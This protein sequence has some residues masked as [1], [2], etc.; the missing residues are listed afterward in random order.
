MIKSFIDFN[1]L[2]KNQLI[3]IIDFAKKIKKNPKKYDSLLKNKSLG[4]LFEKQSTRTRLSFS[5]GMMKLGGNVIELNEN[6]IGFGKRESMKDILKTMSQYLDVLMIRND[7]HDQLKNLDSLNIMPIING[8]SNFSHPCQIL[9]DVLTIEESLGSIKNKEITW[10]GDFNNVLISLIQA[11][12]IFKFKLNILVPRSLIKKYDKKIK[13]NDLKFSYFHDNFKEGLRNAD[14][15]MTDVW[16]SM[17]EKDI[18][19]KKRILKKYQVNDNIMK[20]ANKNAIFMHCLPAH[21]NEEVTSSVIDGN[22]S[23][24]WQ[25]AKN[26]MFAQ[27]SLLYYLINNNE[28]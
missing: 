16:V 2:H 23:V 6:Q 19:N 9:S 17:K 8:L 12:E 27:Q 7:N 3:E 13:I 22:Q 18:N 14:C 5:I 11:A 10:L 21:R 24:V 1:S 25:Q 15:V 26:R 20:L 28:K 4:L